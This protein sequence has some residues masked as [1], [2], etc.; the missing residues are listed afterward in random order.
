METPGTNVAVLG[1]GAMGQALAAAFLG[2]G[3]RTTV[4]NRTTGKA[5]SLVEGGAHEAATVEQA[6]AAAPLVVVCLLDN[7]VVTDVLAGTDVAGRTVVNL[8]NGTPRQARELAE[9][10]ACRGAE[11]VD[12]G[13]MAVPPGIGTDQAL[14]LYSGSQPA[15]DR[16]RDTLAVLGTPQ[17]LGTEP[18]LAALSD[19]ALLTGMY[20]LFGGALQA[21]AL[22]GSGGVAARDFVPMLQQWLAAMATNLPRFAEEIDTGDYATGVVSNLAMQAA[23]FPNLIHVSREQGLRP[24][25]LMPL[26]ALMT[27]RVAGGHGAEDFTGIVELIRT[28]EENK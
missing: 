5:K 11:Y 19:L 16:Y 13:I 25:L 6:V 21:F 14:L 2:A 15:F 7:A 4:W 1:L 8:T 18:G 24:D 26:H 12:G 17:F 3:H 27:E 20:G 10:F 9:S 28:P 23:A 22:A